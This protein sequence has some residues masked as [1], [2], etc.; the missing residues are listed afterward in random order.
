[1]P[2]KL[3]DSSALPLLQ[4]GGLS[5]RLFVLRK[6]TANR[7]AIVDGVEKSLGTPDFFQGSKLARLGTDYL[8]Q[9]Y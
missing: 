8:G 3:F 5:V 9:G 1:M 4:P 7:L 2:L 6:Y